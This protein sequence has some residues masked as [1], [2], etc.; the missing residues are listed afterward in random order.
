M[1]AGRCQKSSSSRFVLAT[2][3]VLA[4]PLAEN[5]AYFVLKE[6]TKGIQNEARHG[7]IMEGVWL[8]GKKGGRGVDNGFNSFNLS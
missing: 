2:T 4:P 7:D 3:G 6:D 5:V 8:E 1:A